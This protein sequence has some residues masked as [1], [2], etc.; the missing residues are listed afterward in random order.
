MA[1]EQQQI[2]NWA[3][4]G[5]KKKGNSIMVMPKPLKGVV[6]V[7]N[8]NSLSRSRSWDASAQ[9]KPSRSVPLSDRISTKQDLD[10]VINDGSNLPDHRSSRNGIEGTPINAFKRLN[11]SRMPI[12]QSS[13]PFYP[14]K[15]E[16]LRIPIPP[17]L[18]RKAI[19][20][21]DMEHL[22]K[23]FVLLDRGPLD[24]E[25]NPKTSEEESTGVKGKIRFILP[26]YRPL[27]SD[28]PRRWKVAHPLAPRVPLRAIQ[29]ENLGLTQEEFEA[30]LPTD[31]DWESDDGA[32][33]DFPG[34][35]EKSEHPESS[36]PSELDHENNQTLDQEDS[37]EAMEHH[38]TKPKTGKS[39]IDIALRISPSSAQLL[40]SFRAKIF[41]TPWALPDIDVQ[42]ITKVH[43]LNQ[44]GS[45][46]INISHYCNV[47]AIHARHHAAFP[48]PIGKPFAHKKSNGIHNIAYD[49]TSPTISKLRTDLC[50]SFPSETENVSVD[51]EVAHHQPLK[52]N[53]KVW[54]AQIPLSRCSGKDTAQ[55]RRLR[56]E[57]ARQE[58]LTEQGGEGEVTVQATGI[59]YRV[60]QAGK[61]F[62]GN[63]SEHGW[64]DLPF[65]GI[66]LPLEEEKVPF[67]FSEAQTDA[68]TPARSLE[69][70]NDDTATSPTTDPEVIL[71]QEQNPNQYLN[72][73]KHQRLRTRK[74]PPL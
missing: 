63:D 11:F 48:F 65:L 20:D 40:A 17:R 24:S 32:H 36:S 55:E 2:P 33:D 58:V 72:L 26:R 14:E 46:S 62:L 57:A 23:C 35:D 4:Y 29:P 71:P 74:S 44:I 60:F 21:G 51:G 73:T 13:I 34:L 27:A 41:T 67:P 56:A 8:L 25:G 68:E 50:L 38:P 5:Q 7:P 42:P 37:M 10:P 31:E 52:F 28:D 1:K 54:K 70:E 19:R 6:T 45:S 30:R 66:E 18:I 16:R 69:P 39:F 12:L 22:N 9:Y 53:P 43:L 61:S 47:L 49:V 59:C 3:L 64:V 15:S